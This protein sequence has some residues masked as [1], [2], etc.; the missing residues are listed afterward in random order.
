MKIIYLCPKCGKELQEE[1]NYAVRGEYP[2]V[3]LDCDENFYRFEAVEKE[4]EE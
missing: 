3:C 1:D 2:F 4:V